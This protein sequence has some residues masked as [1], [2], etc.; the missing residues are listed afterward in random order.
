MFRTHSLSRS[1]GVYSSR[2]RRLICLPCPGRPEVTI[3]G[4]FPY[5]SISTVLALRTLGSVFTIAEPKS[6]RGARLVDCLSHRAAPVRCEI[7]Q[8][9]M[10]VFS[11]KSLTS[12]FAAVNA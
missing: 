6:R 1:P 10:A 9:T 4:H 3:E 7:F 11:H 5:N 12:A 8:V 2:W